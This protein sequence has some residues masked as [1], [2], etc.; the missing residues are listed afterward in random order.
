MAASSGDP[1][2]RVR[3]HDAALELWRGP[4]LA[5]AADELLRS[6]LGGRLAELRAECAGAAGRGPVG[7]GAAC[8]RRGRSGPGRGRTAVA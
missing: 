6:R 4:L 3:C 2:E 1:G 8:A 7:D 5:D